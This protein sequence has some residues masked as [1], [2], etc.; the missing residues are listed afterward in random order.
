[1]I[2][3]FMASF[4]FIDLKLWGLILRLTLTKHC[5]GLCLVRLILF[6]K[7]K[8]KTLKYYIYGNSD[9]KIVFITIR[10]IYCRENIAKENDFIGIV[11]LVFFFFFFFN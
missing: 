2:E 3:K 8:K 6:I 9:V 10:S 1:M 7:R 11:Y 5:G 4:A